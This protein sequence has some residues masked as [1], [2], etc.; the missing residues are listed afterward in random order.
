MSSSTSKTTFDILEW[1]NVIPQ[2]AKC[3]TPLDGIP[4]G[5]S[6]VEEKD[7]LS[8][9]YK[10]TLKTPSPTEVLVCIAAGNHHLLPLQV[11]VRTRTKNKN[12]NLASFYGV[13]LDHQLYQAM[14]VIEYCSYGTLARCI[15]KRDGPCSSKVGKVGVICDITN[16]LEYLHSEGINVHC[17]NDQVVHIRGDKRAVISHF[18]IPDVY[19]H[20]EN[21]SDVYNGQGRMFIAPE[22]NQNNDFKRNERFSKSSD[23]YSLG[24]IIWKLALLFSDRGMGMDRDID[25]EFERRDDRGLISLI[26]MDVSMISIE[27]YVESCNWC[28]NTN[29]E[30][31]P[32]STI[33]KMKFETLKQT[34]EENE[35]LEQQE[36]QQRQDQEVLTEVEKDV[37]EDILDWSQRQDQYQKTN[38]TRYNEQKLNLEPQVETTSLTLQGKRLLEE[39]EDEKCE[40]DDQNP[41]ITGK[42]PKLTHLTDLYKRTIPSSSSYLPEYEKFLKRGAK[43]KKLSIISDSESE[44][45]TTTKRSSKRLSDKKKKSKQ[46]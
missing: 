2:D 17:L 14:T 29:P 35:K 46:G 44:S 18:G 12:P 39:D 23:V 21:H 32:T 13:V 33:L 7:T 3:N 36:H 34:E 15:S 5:T 16:G 26:Y 42:K 27:G 25:N 43:K 4:D 38:Q 28:L 40:K 37:M 1:Y 41:K 6:E 19:Y 31:R 22:Y 24:V 10:C 8:V 30:A 9:R 45:P 20:R 11:D